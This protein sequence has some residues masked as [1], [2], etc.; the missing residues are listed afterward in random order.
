[1]TTLND[2][3]IGVSLA[4]WLATFLTPTLFSGV[5]IDS[6]VGLVLMALIGGLVAFRQRKEETS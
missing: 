6:T 4:A 2:I 3:A 5:H 1:M